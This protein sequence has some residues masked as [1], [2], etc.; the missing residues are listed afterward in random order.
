MDPATPE[1]PVTLAPED[2][3]DADQKERRTRGGLEADVKV[4]TDRFVTEDIVLPEGQSLTPHRIGKAIKDF[5]GLDQAPSTGAVAAVLARWEKIGFAEIDDKPL[6][7]IDYT[8]AGRQKGLSALKA[9]VSAAKKALKG[10]ASSAA[11][12]PAPEPVSAASGF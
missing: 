3:A 4:I 1:T 9:E 7:F 12:A 2:A 6:A 5:N 10:L 11:A 8:E